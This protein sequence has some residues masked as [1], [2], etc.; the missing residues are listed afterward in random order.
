MCGCFL[1]HCF[2]G[3][4]CVYYL[5]FVVL[6]Y[7]FVFP[8]SIYLV[9]IA[10]YEFGFTTCCDCLGHF[11]VNDA[12]SITV[13]LTDFLLQG[14]AWLCVVVADL[15]SQRNFHFLQGECLPT[16]E[17][18]SGCLVRA[19]L[20]VHYRGLCEPGFQILSWVWVLACRWFSYCFLSP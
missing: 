6:C 14:T 4:G 17:L 2:Q 12:S 16:T 20:S 13:L 10:N 8:Q 7:C 18:C 11:N 19:K 5:A 1:L 9:F 3:N 15:P